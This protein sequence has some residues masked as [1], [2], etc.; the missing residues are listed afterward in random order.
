MNDP[1]FP[2]LV[3]TIGVLLGEVDRISLPRQAL[4]LRLSDYISQQKQG[5]VQ[6]HFICT[7]N[8]RRSQIAQVWAAVAA[9][10]AGLDGVQTYSGGT[11]VTAFHANAVAALERV[12]FRIDKPGG[13]NPHYLVHFSPDLPPLTCY[14]K[15]FD[16]ASNPTRDFAAVM[17]CSQADENCPFIP[18][19]MWRLPLTYEDPKV[20]DDT[21]QAAAHYEE[22]VREIGR[23]LVFALQHVN[24][25]S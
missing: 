2:E 22:R 23:E 7:H 14:S 9:A 13:D 16:D 19:A 4:L 11:E 6:L 8:S 3:D 18:G 12:G 25:D 15:A 24:T 10:Y 17:T 1:L 21:P 5:S 20:A